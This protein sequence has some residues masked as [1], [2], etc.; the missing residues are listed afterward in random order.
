MERV[1]LDAELLDI[2]GLVAGKHSA[3]VG[4]VIFVSLWQAASP[5]SRGRSGVVTAVWRCWCCS[6]KAS[7]FMYELSE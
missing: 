1:A 6:G 7:V 2:P 3:G 4:L 5:E